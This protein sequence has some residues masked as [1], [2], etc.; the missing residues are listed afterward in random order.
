MHIREKYHDIER[1]HQ[2]SG[3]T[4]IFSSSDKHQLLFV[5]KLLTCNKTK[6]VFDLL[7]RKLEVHVVLD[8]SAMAHL[9]AVEATDF[10]VM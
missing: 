10:M 4:L 2:I 3:E 7:A 1:S 5:M 6:Y 8:L 9:I